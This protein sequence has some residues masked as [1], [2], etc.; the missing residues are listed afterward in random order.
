MSV[1]IRL[2]RLGKNKVPFYRIVVV[3]S[4]KKRD[5]ASLD[6]LGTYDS[7]KGTL[8]SFNQER[9]DYWVSV[10]ATPT[11]VVKRLQ[12]MYKKHGAQSTAQTVGV[13]EAK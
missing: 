6:N 3:D 1:K 12:K 5:G 9:M 2:S 7:L 13:E 4:R 11:D 10:G 8:L